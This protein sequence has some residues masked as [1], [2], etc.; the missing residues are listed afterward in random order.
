MMRS[1]SLSKQQDFLLC[2]AMHLTGLFIW[3]PAHFMWKLWVILVHCCYFLYPFLASQVLGAPKGKIDK[4]RW[5]VGGV[6]GM[7][8]WE[9]LILATS[10]DVGDIKWERHTAGRNLNYQGVLPPRLKV[11]TWRLR[12]GKWLAQ[13]HPASEKQDLGQNLGRL[14]HRAVSVLNSLW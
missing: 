1:A 12:A 8:D 14:R 13:G 2:E 6:P 7:M 5:V 9:Q 4:E 3:K 11:K 10:P